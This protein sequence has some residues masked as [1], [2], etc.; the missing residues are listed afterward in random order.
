[1]VNP[2]R[3]LLPTT[4]G[5]DRLFSTINE[6]DHLLTE[7]KKYTQSYPPYNIIKTDDTNYSIEIAVAGFKREELDIS[8]ENSKLTVTG[9]TIDVDEKEYLHKG[10]GTRDFTH[11]FR[12]SDSIIIKS[13]DI[14]DGLLVI[15]L[16]NIIPEEKKPRKIL[17]GN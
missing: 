11:N 6:F 13:A 1:M 4:V 5:F 15:S 7:G 14:M 3:S 16:V 10:I 17:I 8:F 12:L 9:K 2:Y